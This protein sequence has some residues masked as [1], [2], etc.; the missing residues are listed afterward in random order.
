MLAPPVAEEVLVCAL[1][2]LHH[3][4]PAVP[5]ELREEVERD[6]DVV[7]DRLVL[8]ADEQW[9]KILHLPPV[10]Q[11]LVMIGLVTPADAPGVLKLVVVLLAFVADGERGHWPR[12]QLAHQRDV[13]RGINTARKQ[14]AERNVRNH[15]A[16]D[17]L[18]E[19]SGELN[20]RLR[21]A[22][23]AFGQRRRTIGPAVPGTGALGP[24]RSGRWS[25]RVRRAV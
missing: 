1:S 14:D 3:R 19:Q 17:R 6:T 23:V 24:G 21:F 7:G 18:L 25:G 13:H 20:Y 16:G 12:H 8:E 10:N 11:R 4:G 22:D 15:A 5:D 9:Q 2:D